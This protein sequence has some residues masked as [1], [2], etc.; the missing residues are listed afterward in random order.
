MLHE[1]FIF[2]LRKVVVDNAISSPFNQ[3]LGWLSQ[4]KDYF[5]AASVALDLLRDV[6]SLRDLRRAKEEVDF[7]HDR[8]NLEGLL[9]GIFPLYTESSDS[10]DQAVPSP[11]QSVL[12]Q[13]ADMTVGCLLKGG[14]RMS[15]TLENFVRRDPNY[16]PGRACLMLVAATVSSLSHDSKTTKSVMGADYEWPSNDMLPTE[17]LVWPLRSLFQ[18]GVARDYL[19]TIL[20]LLNAAIP[21]EL[22]RRGRDGVAGTSPESLEICTS[23]VS[24]IVASSAAE[25]LLSLVDEASGMRYWSSLEH[26][27]Q[28]ELSLISI[29]GVFPLLRQPEVRSWALSETDK[30]IQD[31]GSLVASNAPDLP[32]DWLRKLCEACLANAGCDLEYISPDASEHSQGSDDSTAD[33]GTQ[34]HLETHRLAIEAL[35]PSSGSGGLDFDV[36]I[37][38]LLLLAYRT[39][40]WRDDSCLSTQSMLDAACYLAGRHRKEEPMF[41]FD[42]P[43][44]M[45]Q[46]ALAGNISAGANLIGGK[47]GLV[48]MC[49]D[50]LIKGAGMSMDDAE[51]YILNSELA[52]SSAYRKMKHVTKQPDQSPFELT[53]EHRRVLWLLDEYVLSIKTF[54]D[55]DTMHVR[56]KVD[57]VFAARSCLR[58]WFLLSWKETTQATAWLVDWLRQRLGIDQVRRKRLACSALTCALMWPT[59]DEIIDAGEI[60]ATLD[61]NLLANALKMEGLFLVQL[62]QSSCGLVESLPPSFAQEVLRQVEAAE[63]GEKRNSSLHVDV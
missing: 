13:L 39:V 22:R 27:T 19:P 30:R 52:K 4:S 35:T 43:N 53:D 57:P 50:A 29:D 18:L 49:C 38:A 36:M 21:D 2:S 5:T 47:N 24:M 60:D 44:V 55:F 45:K 28:L 12:T 31:S 14:L 62:A 56:G 11:S 48:L 51:D 16:D 58:T 23:I 17:D 59:T 15:H 10:S 33:D 7:D 34:K 54:G 37:P 25:L 1:H 63:A 3:V 32:S 6:D 9:D 41:A 8:A 20:L 61:E 40:P 42:G 46:C 26:D